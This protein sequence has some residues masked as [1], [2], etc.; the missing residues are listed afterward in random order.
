MA[1]FLV[2]TINRRKTVLIFNQQR[3][4]NE[5]TFVTDTKTKIYLSAKE[6]FQ[7]RGYSDV[8]LR[9]IAEHAGTTIGNLTYHFPK[10]EAIMLRLQEELYSTFF[11]FV[12]AEI[13]DENA[14]DL[15]K[16]SIHEIQEIRKTNMYYYKY[17]VNI[18][19]EFPSMK[20]ELLKFRKRL[21]DFY[22]KIFLTLKKT[23]IM[24]DDI[25]DSEYEKLTVLVSHLT[26]SWYQMTSPYYDGAD[27]LELS[28]GLRVLVGAYMI[29]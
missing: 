2:Y 8:S 4:K 3:K 26:Y 27:E 10:K 13:T 12:D 22:L 6:L 21:T 17:I 19:E 29:G 24:R 25:E 11:H 5:V 16:N 23:G 18:H 15:L 1:F 28:E 20:E 9:D 7:E 14:L